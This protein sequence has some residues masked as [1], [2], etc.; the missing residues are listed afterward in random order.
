MASSAVRPVTAATFDAEVL[1]SP[2][3]VLAY[4]WAAWC[5]QCRAVRPLVE[6][7]AAEYRGRADVVSVDAEAE[8]ALADR[9]GV[10]SL[11]TFI[12]FDGGEVVDGVVGAVA[13]A[14]LTSR[15]DARLAPADA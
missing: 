12:L 10:R 9:Y 5:A 6:A 11:P 14:S 2:R 13:R 15:L 3:P 4:V 8:A 7:L 1:A